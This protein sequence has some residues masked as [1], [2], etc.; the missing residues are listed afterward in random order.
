MN[1]AEKLLEPTSLND[2]KLVCDILP[3][4]DALTHLIWN[5]YLKEYRSF[6]PDLM[7][8]LETRSKVKVTVTGKWNVTIRH[9][10]MHS[11]TKLPSK[12]HL[13]NKF[14]IPTLKKVRDVL[15]TRI[16]K[17]RSKVNVTVTRKWYVTLRHPKISIPNLEF[18]PQRIYN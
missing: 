16:L 2:Q 11:Q 3:S 4:Q 12:V 1:C 13:H 17:T 14:G 7:L 9:F 6:A 15:Q 10:K 8:I 5:S 18:L